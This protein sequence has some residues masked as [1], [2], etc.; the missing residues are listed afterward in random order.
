MIL[1]LAE[2][3]SVGKDIAKV[4]GAKKG[5]DGYFEGNNYIVTWAMGHLVTLKDPESYDKKYAKWDLEYL[6]IIPK[7]MKLEVIKKT[8]KQYN[9][10]KEL[11]HRKEVTEI[12]IATDAGR[13]G[14]LVA[15]WIL[16]KSNVHKKIKR[17]WI[18]SVTDKAI[19]EGFKNLKDGRLYEN[20]YS[21][22]VARAEADWIVGI[23]ATRAL[24]SKYNAQI[25]CGRV[26]TPT[27]A[28]IESLENEIHEFKPIPYYTIECKSKNLKFVWYDKNNNT[29]LYDKEKCERILNLIK[30]NNLKITNIVR[31]EHKT[32]APLLYDLTQ[33][34]RDANNLFG[35]S[36]KETLSI[37]QSLYE[38]HK[39]LTYPRTDSKYITEDIVETLKDRVKACSVSPYS[40]I[41]AKILSAQIKGN[42]NFVN[43]SKVSD[44]HA[45]IPTE[46]TVFISDLTDRE[47]KIYDLVVKR[48][49]AVLSKPF[50]YEKI[51]I[52]GE[53][54]GEKFISK[55][56]LV[57]SPG[58]K[59]IYGQYED[60]EELDDY[61][62]SNI[63]QFLKNQSSKIDNA[64]YIVKETTP[65]LRF[66]EAGLLA[67]MEN[68]V[69][70]M[71]TAD[72]TLKKTIKETSGLGTVA[73]RADIIEK[74]FNSYVIEKRDK[75]IYITSKG[76]Q[77]LEL[78]PKDLKSPVLTAKWEQTLNEISKGKTKKEN[79][80]KDMQDYTEKIINE[81][82]FSDKK[83]VHEN[84]TRTKC[85]ECE[86]Y[87][88]EVNGKKGKMLVCQ[89]RECGY[90]KQIAQITNSRCPNCHKKL[91]L[92]GEGDKKIFV[93]K[94]G[95]KEK[96]SSFTKRKETEQKT[97][98]SK[99]ASKYLKKQ[100]K[101]ENIN[102]ALADALS[103]LKL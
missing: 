43:N 67:A 65:P 98:S 53:V 88:L 15:R 44:H 39:V 13:E 42:K 1:V 50:E 24:T 94:C 35:F 82:K 23:N 69:K 71:K 10:V 73:T 9:K 8:S 79:F 26:Q 51:Q 28:M 97:I 29:R 3:P 46:E 18:S 20:L 54:S 7:Q 96:L 87:L 11:L 48:F 63:D 30:Q 101:E 99:E 56:R 4:L 91:E 49:L 86:N 33:L 100:N 76:K 77:L 103:K 55:G 40:K 84:E 38:H 72:E 70:Y 34:Q 52:E 45:I 81:I 92:K 31:S 61:L 21:C 6:P 27:I 37:M 60:E 57:I 83:Y 14:E 85:P 59:E 16:E 78:V 93:C 19:K 2:K 66:T 41:C 32:F 17:L 80:I 47:R 74:L 75:Y 64:N 95:Y 62:N 68:P 5:S 89:N 22:A 36:P 58:W 102:T 90:K 25:S 12:V